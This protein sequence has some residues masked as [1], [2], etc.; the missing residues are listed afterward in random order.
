LQRVG[1]FLLL[2]RLVCDGNYV[3]Q[4]L[5]SEWGTEI[6]TVHEQKPLPKRFRFP[7]LLSAILIMGDKAL[8]VSSED[9]M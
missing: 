3:C 8:R 7:S 5:I 9:F 1:E 2:S 4:R 6:I